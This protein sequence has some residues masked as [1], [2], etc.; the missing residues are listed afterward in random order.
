MERL[1]QLML[2]ARRDELRSVAEAASKTLRAARSV[3]RVLIVTNAIQGWVQS[4]ASKF[5]PELVDEVADI[6]VIS[7]RSIFEPQ[8][9][10]D[11]A[12]WKAFCFQRLVRYL[13][14][15]EP[16][17]GHFVSIGD[18]WHER[19]AALEV[20]QDPNLYCHIKSVKLFERPSVAQIAE[21]L[22]VV[23]PQMAFLS[24]HGGVLDLSMQEGMVLGPLVLPTITTGNATA[25]CTPVHS[26]TEFSEARKEEEEEEEG[27]GKQG[28]AMGVEVTPP[29]ETVLPRQLV[30]V[31]PKKHQP[32]PNYRWNAP[33]GHPLARKRPWNASA[34]AACRPSVAQAQRAW[35]VTR[36][37]PWQL[38]AEGWDRRRRF[39]QLG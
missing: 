16:D 1:L 13:K 38:K 9:V 27:R 37:A 3:G 15:G 36:K 31:P 6:P 10:V 12:R 8:G 23:A 39:G 34:C 2:W 28:E 29:P 22:N 32:G 19:A 26:A 30:V 11:P 20:A 5:L 18:S 21:Q 4:T 25:P 24:L 17:V 7:A 14:V 35:F 33:I